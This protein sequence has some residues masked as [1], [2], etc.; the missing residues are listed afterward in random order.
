MDRREWAKQ[1]IDTNRRDDITREALVNLGVL[2]YRRENPTAALSDT[3]LMDI[4]HELNTA[5][6]NDRTYMSSGRK[7]NERGEAGPMTGRAHNPYAELD[8]VKRLLRQKKYR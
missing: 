1:W 7:A 4:R 3:T 2:A 6:D 8:A 5:Y